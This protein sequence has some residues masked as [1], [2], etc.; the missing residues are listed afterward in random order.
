MFVSGATYLQTS[1][2]VCKLTPHHNV[3][4]FEKADLHD[5]G[6]FMELLLLWPFCRR[7]SELLPLE[8]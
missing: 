8:L 6:H 4:S 3:F 2:V 1:L 7:K 5:V